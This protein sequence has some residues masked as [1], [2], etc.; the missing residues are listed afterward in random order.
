MNLKAIVE[1]KP[2][3]AQFVNMHYSDA[4]YADPFVNQDI[5]APRRSFN[6]DSPM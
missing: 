2:E 6:E 3:A 4:K 5:H 1:N